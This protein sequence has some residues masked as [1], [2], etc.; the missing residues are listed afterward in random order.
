[1]LPDDRGQVGREREDE[2]F[3]VLPFLSGEPE[4]GSPQEV[5]G[6]RNRAVVQQ[7]RAPNLGARRR[8]HAHLGVDIAQ[9]GN[10]HVLRLPLE[11]LLAT[12]AK[13]AVQGVEAVATVAVL[14]GVCG[15]CVERRTLCR[16]G[17][18]REPFI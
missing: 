11:A 15:I 17:T 7:T 10:L 5:I 2:L 13:E 9:V 3:Q 16:P 8:E 4:N 18:A 6:I 1:M 12:C 14:H